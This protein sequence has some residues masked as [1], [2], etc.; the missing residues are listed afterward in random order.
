MIDGAS[1]SDVDFKAAA[2]DDVD[3]LDVGVAG[4]EGAI[5]SGASVLKRT[6]VSTTSSIVKNTVNFTGKG[7]LSVN[8]VDEVITGVALDAVSSVIEAPKL[9]YNKSV[10]EAGQ[11]LKKTLKEQGVPKT[12]IPTQKQAAQA[13]RNQRE[14][15][16]DIVD[17]GVKTAVGATNGTVKQEIND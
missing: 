12:K 1:F 2:F 7:D 10:G 3:F 13:V 15:Q 4:V 16:Q 14:L 11:Q 9:K 17:T 8:E 6:V 5:T